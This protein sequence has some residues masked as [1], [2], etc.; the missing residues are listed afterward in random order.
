MARF[1]RIAF[2]KIH[3]ILLVLRVIKHIKCK[4]VHDMI[5]YC[6]CGGVLI[7]FLTGSAVAALPSVIFH[8]KHLSILST[9]VKHHGLI[10]D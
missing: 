6:I 4:F 10:S 5:F 3:E 9:N 2:F 1:E 7:L 8:C